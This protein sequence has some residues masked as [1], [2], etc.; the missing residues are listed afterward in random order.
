MVGLMITRVRKEVVGY[1][2]L[3]FLPMEELEEWR[4]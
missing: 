4:S 2:I 3:A 1:T